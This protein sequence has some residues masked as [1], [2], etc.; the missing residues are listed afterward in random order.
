MCGI[1]GTIGNEDTTHFLLDGLQKLEYRGYDSAGIYVNDQAG[2]DY[3]VKTTGKISDLRAKVGAEV[4]GSL[5]IAHTRWATHGEPSDV[6]A[7]P[8]FSDSRRFYMVHN[9][10]INNYKALA[11]KYL[12]DIT[13]KSSTD[14]EV[15]V[16]LVAHF[17]EQE[18]LTTEKAFVHVLGLIDGSY[19]FLLV[20]TETPDRIY[21]A[22]N[23]S[24][25]L[26]G[27]A[28]GFNVIVSDAM[29]GLSVTKEFMEVHDG[30]YGIVT[31][32]AIELKTLAGETVVRKPY[33]VELDGAD[34][35][36]GAYETYM[37]KEIDEQPAVIRGLVQTYFNDDDEPVISQDLL[38]ALGKA[39]RLYIVAAGTSY[40]AGLVGKRIFEKYAHIP[41]EVH[42]SSEFGYHWPLLSEH[43]FFIFLTQSG[44]T[45]DSREVLVGVNKRELPSLT[46]TN[47]ANSTLS[48]EATYTLLLH[49]GPEIAVASTKAY[50]SQIAVEA[51][52]AKAMGEVKK[53]EAAQKLELKHELSMIASHI[54]DLVGDKELFK[55]LVVDYLKDQHDAFYIGR[56]VDYDVSLESALKLKEISYTHAEGFA[57]G[58]LKH[59]T[60]ALI[61]ENTPVI[62]FITEKATAGHTYSNVQEV[63]ARGA[64]VLVIA[65]ASVAQE[66]ATIVLP[67][68]N[69]DLSPILSVVAGQ[70]LAYYATLQRGN[71]VDQPRNLAKSVTVE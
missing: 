15:I 49:A 21:I 54:S 37:L 19:A 24:P 69:D 70:L 62:A 33:H 12:Q 26:L 56:G 10:V 53:V 60:I 28:D 25:L 5:G 23:K 67:D 4:S 71:N 9:G 1:V 31:R 66:N 52:L 45:A 2:H 39:D 63:K 14:T 55:E 46:I 32:D 59:G 29:A 8:H 51:I 34:I 13:L 42:V 35:S 48:R 58:E 68:V 18:G 44:E 41:T 47:V 22:K 50:T 6:N 11:A 36:K 27:L 7:H 43:P 65:A 17:V 38:T 61:E 16:Q 40:H 57:A 3:L 20:D 64:H 30:E